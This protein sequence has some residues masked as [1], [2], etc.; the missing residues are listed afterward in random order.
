MQITSGTR[1]RRRRHIIRPLIDEV[2]HY[3]SRVQIVKGIA[4]PEKAR[5]S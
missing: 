4:N 2:E 3:I 5:S 1:T